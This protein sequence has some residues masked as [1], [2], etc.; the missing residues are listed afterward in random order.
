MFDLPQRW[1]RAVGESRGG[2]G[3]VAEISGR[4]AGCAD[5]LEKSAASSMNTNIHRLPYW[6]VNIRAF[7]ASLLRERSS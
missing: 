1:H 6:Q 7:G 3:W 4:V 5:P 2:G